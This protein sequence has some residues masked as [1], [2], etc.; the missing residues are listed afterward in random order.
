MKVLK[1][2][3]ISFVG[4]FV[5]VLFYAFILNQNND[6]VT[7]NVFQAIVAALILTCLYGIMFWG[8]FMI[9]LVVLDLL[10]IVRNQDNLRIKLLTEWVLISAPFI[11]WVIRYKQWIFI[12][13]VLAFLLTQLFREKLIVK[14]TQA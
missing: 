8:L 6:N 9:S 10:L 7:Y 2:N 13:G 11:Y 3:W 4:V 1:T 14:A 12:A 5:V